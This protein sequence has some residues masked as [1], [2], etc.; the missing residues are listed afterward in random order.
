[1]KTTILVICLFAIC[2]VTNAQK[3]PPAAV[4]KAFA[5]KFRNVEKVKWSMEE[6]TEWEA[7]FKMNGK[8]ASA[9]FDLA[10]KWLETEIEIEKSELPAAVKDAINKQYSGAKIG[11]CSNID[12]PTFTGYEIAMNDKGKKFEVQVTKDGKLKVNK[13]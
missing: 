5:E 2:S 4:S 12:S 10:G 7:E 9:S 13:E 3:T 6:A 8:E 1:M 11:E